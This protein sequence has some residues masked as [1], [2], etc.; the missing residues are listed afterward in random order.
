LHFEIRFIFVIL[1]ILG[2]RYRLRVEYDENHGVLMGSIDV[3]E[4]GQLEGLIEAPGRSQKICG[5]L[6]ALRDRAELERTV[7]TYGGT[8]EER[9]EYLRNGKG[10]ILCM[11]TQDHVA[12]AGLCLTY[13]GKSFA[14]KY[15]GECGNVIF[16]DSGSDTLDGVIDEQ[17]RASITMSLEMQ[18]P[19][20]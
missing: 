19:L 9:A 11:M 13:D 20:L 10:A 18:D 1:S 4:D 7:K 17:L 3:R 16:K 2:M 6:T 5:T 8:A 12:Y 14:G 15:K